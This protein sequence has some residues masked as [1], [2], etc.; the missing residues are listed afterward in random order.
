MGK[1]APVRLDSCMFTTKGAATTFFK[2]ML[3]KYAVGRRV[4]EDDA[5]HLIS[6]LKHHSEYECKVGVGISHFTIMQAEFGTQCFCIIRLDGS[7]VD[8]SYMHCIKNYSSK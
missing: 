6:L 7:T 3:K 4:S 5:V 8:F 1:S 2:E